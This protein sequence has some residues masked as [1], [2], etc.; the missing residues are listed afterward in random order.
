VTQSPTL[1]LADVNLLDGDRF[2]QGQPYDQWKIL[3]QQAPVYWHPG[4]EPKD[5]RPGVAGFWC[6]TKYADVIRVSRDPQTF[7]SGKGITLFTNPELPPQPEF[8]GGTMLITSDPPRHVRLRRLVN[9]GF[10]PRMVAVLEPHIRGIVTQI[11]DDIAPRGACDF[12][13]DAAALLPLAVICD[14]MGVHQPDWPYMFDLTNKVLGA[15][16]PEYRSEHADAE[17]TGEKARMDMFGYFTK[18]IAERGTDRKDDLLGVILDADI[19]GEKLNQL[20]LLF[21]CFLLIVAGNETTRNATSG[22]LLALMQHP[23]QLEQLRRHPELLPSA[24]EEILR[25]TS[26]VT[27]MARVSTTETEI[28]GQ[29]IGA[30]QNVVMWYPSANRDEEVFPDGDVFNIERSPN[31][32]IAFGI[33]EHFCLGAGLARLEL[34][35]MFEELLR[36]IPDMEQ[37][38][39]VERL[40]SNFI[41]GIKHMPVAYTRA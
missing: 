13:T 7:I 1:T 39:P 23:D 29:A 34:R 21:F 5:G 31:D 32:H 37:T 3:R 26:P 12:V 24:I 22:G 33:G 2:V 9:K 38:G 36:R 11:L 30:N 28:R 35:V 6:I 4:I 10:T 8:G 19:D 15:D 16:D 27:H 25:W 14:M 40:R 41:G 20:E 17:L 18:L